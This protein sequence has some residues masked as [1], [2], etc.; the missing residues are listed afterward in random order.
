MYV[1]IRCHS[2]YLLVLWKLNNIDRRRAIVSYRVVPKGC[3]VVKNLPHVHM[4]IVIIEA[5]NNILWSFSL[6]KCVEYGG[7]S[8]KLTVI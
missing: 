8:V 6:V 7:C 3:G 5:D 4:V 1:K 2:G